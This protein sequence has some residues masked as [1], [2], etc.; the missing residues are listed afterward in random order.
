M[1]IT[2]ELEAFFVIVYERL[3]VRHGNAFALRNHRRTTGPCSDEVSGNKDKSG[4]MTLNK[5]M[6]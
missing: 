5:A 6:R 1:R 2:F 4:L 3:K